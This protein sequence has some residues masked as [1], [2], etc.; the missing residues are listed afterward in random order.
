MI[1]NITNS[2]TINDWFYL[3]PAV[4]FIDFIVIVLS[5]YPGEEPYFKVNALNDWY[6]KFGLAAVG[7]DVLSILI[8]IM[9]T[10][11]I[12][13]SLSL[14]NPLYFIG[15]LFLFQLFHDIIFYL[16]VI[17]PIPS[18]HNQMIDVF[19]S[20]AEENGAKVLVADSL[21]MIGATAVGSLLKT[22]PGHY[23]VALNFVT[24]YSLFYI[25][26]TRTPITV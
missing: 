2:N 26:Y 12:Y 22:L 17:L 5:K 19:K 3:V 25:I 10:R 24:L 14:K 23:T 8:G 6:D 15:I 7:S 4:I 11:Y 13:T 20:Y 18:G 1:G 9:V 21:M 16:F